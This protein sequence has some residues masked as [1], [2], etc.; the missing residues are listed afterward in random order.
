MFGNMSEKDVIETVRISPVDAKKG[1]SNKSLEDKV[2]GDIL[3]HFGGF[4]KKSWRSNDILWGRLDALCQLI[5]TLFD[6]ARV[7]KVVSDITLR[8]KI[9]EGL[10]NELSLAALFSQSV[11]SYRNEL[12]SW[13][14]RLLSED[15]KEREK[16][17]CEEGKIGMLIEAAQLEI[18]ENDLPEV[19]KDAVEEQAKWNQ[20]RISK[21]K[22]LRI[23]GYDPGTDCFVSADGD[24]DP[25][26]V[27]VASKELAAQALERFK[28]Q[29]DGSE[30]GNFFR[31]SY[32][33]GSESLL[34][35]IPPLVLLEIATKTLLV[36]RNCVLK[37]SGSFSK[38]IKKN[39]L[40]K[41]VNSFLLLLHWLIL[42]LRKTPSTTKKYLSALLTLVLL[43]TL[44][45]GIG[46][47]REI[48]YPAGTVS[49]PWLIIFIVVPVFLLII[50]FMY[51]RRRFSKKGK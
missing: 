33:V 11:E 46:W 18:L 23:P 31:N 29:K 22:K 43:L 4:F 44:L 49:L 30:I 2:S 7:K 12:E 5:E 13:L 3:F 9:R 16:A 42:F 1:Y 39:I 32:K 34:R 40:Y 28:K 21:K 38:K 20:F 45:V 36:L 27:S 17:L 48:I 37:S 41:I 25:L 51:L 26:V 35:D 19:I 50:Q 47:R 15:H 24:L 14:H 6:K 10:K 8:E